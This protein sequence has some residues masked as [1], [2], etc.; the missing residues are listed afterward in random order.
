[1]VSMGGARR[2]YLW[3]ELEDGIYGFQNIITCKGKH[4]LKLQRKHLI[5]S[6]QSGV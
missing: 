2:W 3:V 4:I 5:L 1:M 6:G